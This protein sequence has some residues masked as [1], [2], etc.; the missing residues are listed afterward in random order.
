[1]ALLT[2]RETFHFALSNSVEL[3]QEDSIAPG[4]KD[5]ELSLRVNAMLQLLDLEECA[6]TYVGSDLVRGVSGGQRKR[7]SIGEVLI[8][9]ARALLLDE[10][11]T[12]KAIL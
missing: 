11:S 8:T 12:G 2:V 9:N 6:D 4:Q 5:Q 7:V 10:Y 3:D 1:M